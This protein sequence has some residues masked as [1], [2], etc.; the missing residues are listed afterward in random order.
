VRPSRTAPARTRAP[1]GSPSAGAAHRSARPGA[2]AWGAILASYGGDAILGGLLAL[3]RRPR[4]PL[5][6]STLATLGFPLPPLAL[7]LHLP[8]A[9]VAAGAPLAGLGS[10]VGS[11]I[12][13]TVTQ[14]RVPA[15]ALSRV[16]SF[17]MV[18]A[19]AFGPVAFA[20]AGPAAAAFGTRAVLGFGAGWAAFGTL[21]V[22]AV[23][24]IRDLSWQDTPPPPAAD[25][26]TRTTGPSGTPTPGLPPPPAPSRPGGGTG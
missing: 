11:A 12:S 1:A 18:G 16:G 20:A 4:R 2:R 26:V 3:G 23:P 22:L 15:E 9:A 13:T 7:A 25:S 5:L 24:S 10:A 8:V 6:V 19:F 14:Q 17:N 21:V